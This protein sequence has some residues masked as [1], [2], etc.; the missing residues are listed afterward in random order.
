MSTSEDAIVALLPFGIN[1]VAS[2]EFERCRE[3]CEEELLVR[4]INSVLPHTRVRNFR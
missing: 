3:P 4:I 1:A 2:R